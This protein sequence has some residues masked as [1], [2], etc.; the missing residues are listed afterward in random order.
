VAQKGQPGG[1]VVSR[2]RLIVLCQ[3]TPNHVL[4]DV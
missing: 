3:Y 4:V 2:N 1:T